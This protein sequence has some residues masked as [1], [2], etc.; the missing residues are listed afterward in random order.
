VA[1]EP[2]EQALGHTAPDRVG[3]ERVLRALVQLH[4]REAG[5]LDRLCPD[6]TERLVGVTPARP[7]IRK[8]RRA[9]E[10]T[11][12]RDVLF[13]PIRHLLA[14]R[15]TL[16]LPRLRTANRRRHELPLHRL[17]HG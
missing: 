10:S 16:G 4:V 2:L 1:E 15:Q 6:L 8:E 12:A 13:D 7:R 11:L 5:R 9:A 3:R 14:D 17:V